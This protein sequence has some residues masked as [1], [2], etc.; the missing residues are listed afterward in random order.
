M[1]IYTCPECGHDLTEVIL[2]TYPAKREMCCMNCGWSVIL[3]NQ[4]QRIPY[5]KD[6]FNTNN[7]N[8]IPDSCKNCPNHYSNGGSGIC[9]C[10]LG[11]YVVT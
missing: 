4:I 11:D 7:F 5:P 8:T 1:I 9:N 10:I 2:T 6:E 3:K